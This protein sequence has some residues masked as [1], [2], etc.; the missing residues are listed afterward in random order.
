M[1]SSFSNRVIFNCPTQKPQ[2]TFADCDLIGYVASTSVTLIGPLLLAIATLFAMPF[3]YIS[4]YFCKC[5]GTSKQTPECCCSCYTTSND[6]EDKEQPPS[7]HIQNHIQQK[8]TTGKHDPPT[9]VSETE[10]TT[11]NDKNKEKNSA[12]TTENRK[13]RGAPDASDSGNFETLPSLEETIIDSPKHYSTFDIL[14]VK[15][16]AILLGIASIVLFSV[17]MAAAGRTKSGVLKSIDALGSIGRVLQTELDEIDAALVIPTYD[18]DTDSFNTFDLLNSTSQGRDVAE[19]FNNVSTT[20]EGVIKSSTSPVEGALNT[21]STILF[22]V[23]LLPCACMFLNAIFAVFNIRK[24]GPM[25]NGFITFLSLIVIWIAHGVIGFGGFV[26]SDV[27]TEIT[28]LAN[29]EQNVVS[30]LVECPTSLLDDA[31]AA[32]TKLDLTEAG[33]ACLELNKTCVIPTSDYLQFAR[34][35]A[36]GRI[37]DCPVDFLNCTEATFSRLLNYTQFAMKINSSIYDLD[38]AE[39][40]GVVC[41][42]TS[43]TECTIARCSEKCTFE[44]GS[45]SDTGK[46]SM[47]AITQ[48][49]SSGTVT[50]IFADVG[51]KFYVCTSL[52][53]LIF[54]EMVGP[55]DQTAEGLFSYY[56]TS[57]VIGLFAIVSIYVSSWGSKRFI[58]LDVIEKEKNKLM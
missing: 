21:I 32:F 18:Y 19:Y 53:T 28:A 26:I 41:R 9:G 44:N 46:S 51:A 35:A 39:E 54:S 3:F 22:I 7:D 56:M 42:N 17:G 30:A 16:Y 25:L 1:S 15:T 57:G 12:Q 49:K 48:F 50:S 40:N 14:R 52:L 38:G 47:L 34:D 13:T 45:R 23:V 27:C 2:I 24:W 33:K 4:R 11:I 31:R 10:L 5:C 58:N 20:I 55:C 8:T 29:Q 43:R 6:D 36:K 37:F